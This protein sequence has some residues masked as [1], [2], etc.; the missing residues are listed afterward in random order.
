M[1]SPQLPLTGVAPEEM[2]LDI[3]HI[4]EDVLVVNKPS[5]LVVHPGEGA[6]QWNSGQ[7]IGPLDPKRCGR[8]ASS[9]LGAPH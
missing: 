1:A 3:R 8:S 6:C 7:W 2:D 5:G 4:D 9:R